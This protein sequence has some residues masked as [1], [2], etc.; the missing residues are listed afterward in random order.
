MTKEKEIAKLE[1]II[2][3]VKQLVNDYRKRN[4]NSKIKIHNKDMLFW[5]LQKQVDADNRISKLEAYIKVIITLI[6]SI[7]GLIFSTMVV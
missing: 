5:L 3:D 4:G 6:L 2:T 1:N 7:F